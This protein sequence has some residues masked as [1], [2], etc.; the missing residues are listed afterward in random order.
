MD[1]HDAAVDPPP[2]GRWLLVRC[3]TNLDPAWWV[4]R[5]HA[6]NDYCGSDDGNGCKREFITQWCELPPTAG[7]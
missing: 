3:E 5:L 4:G 2:E 1:V 7:R 6:G